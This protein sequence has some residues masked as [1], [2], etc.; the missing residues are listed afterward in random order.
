MFI[1]LYWHLATTALCVNEQ[2][3]KFSSAPHST[4]HVVIIFKNLKK[5]M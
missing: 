1:S 2:L 4:H 5:L 3:L